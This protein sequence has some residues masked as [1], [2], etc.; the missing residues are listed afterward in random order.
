[1]A[2]A[3]NI[4]F[5]ANGH[6][7]ATALKSFSP[8]ATVEEIDATVLGNSSRSWVTGFKSGTLSAEGIWNADGADADEIHDILSAA[9]V[10]SSTLVVTASLGSLAVGGDAVMMEGPEVKYGVN[11]P[12]GELIMASAE[13]RASNGISFG[14]WLMSSQLNAGTTNGTAVDNGAATTNGGVFHVHLYNDDASDVDTKVQ[15]ST[16]GSTW[17]DLTNVNNLSSTHTAGS[18]TVASGTTVNRY[19]RAVSVVTGGNTILV[20]AAFARR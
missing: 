16:D 18:A 3:K 13:L 17:V 1:M 6:N 19:L 15:H 11:T 9:F 8:E 2:I 7:L 14:K 10:N 5:L 20:S 12:L 4:T